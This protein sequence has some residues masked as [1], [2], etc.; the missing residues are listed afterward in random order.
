MLDYAARA[1][2]LKSVFHLGAMSAIRME[3]ELRDYY[4][5]KVMEGKN[6]IRTADAACLERGTQ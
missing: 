5:R 3:G 4:Q 6:K 1:A 2:P